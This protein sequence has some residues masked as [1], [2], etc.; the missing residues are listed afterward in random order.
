TLIIRFPVN[1]IE[2]LLDSRVVVKDLVMEVKNEPIP[3]IV[4][5]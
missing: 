3:R 5:R 4:C 2:R 1:N